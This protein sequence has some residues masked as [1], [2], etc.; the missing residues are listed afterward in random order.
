[1]QFFPEKGPCPYVGQPMVAL[2]RFETPIYT[3]LSPENAEKR[4]A[5]LKRLAEFTKEKG[6]DKIVA[7]QGYVLDPGSSG[8]LDPT[9]VEPEPEPEPE[10]VTRPPN[11][12]IALI[13]PIEDPYA[14]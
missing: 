6:C 2:S 13:A 3:D 8:D 9:P 1:M 10:C 11:P 7:F 5:L 12:D 4:A 14:D